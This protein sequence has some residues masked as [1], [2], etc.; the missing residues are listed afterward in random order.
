MKSEAESLPFI[1]DFVAVKQRRREIPS[2]GN[3]AQSQKKKKK[4][5]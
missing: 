1:K 5:N 4:F 2:R 3:P